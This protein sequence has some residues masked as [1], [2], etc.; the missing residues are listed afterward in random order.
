M[1]LKEEVMTY[2]YK[3]K[4]TGI[5]TLSSDK[6]A[7]ASDLDWQFQ[8]WAKAHPECT[9]LDMQDCSWHDRMLRRIFY[10][11]PSLNK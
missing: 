7:A 6:V 5:E 3:A 8:E 4:Y 10:Y 11:D 1:R 2:Q 9:I